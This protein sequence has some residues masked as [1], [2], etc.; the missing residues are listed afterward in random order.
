MG[1]WELQAAPLDTTGVHACVMPD[2]TV[3]YWSYDELE[4]NN[5]DRCKWQLWDEAGGP[6]EPTARI[7]SRNLF[8]AGHCWLG[9]GRL[10]VAG[11]QSWNW[12][13]QGI[14]GADHDIHTYSPIDRTWT[15]HKDMPAGRYYPTCLTL[16]DGT[17]LIVSGAWTRV[18]SNG[19]NHDYEIFDGRTNE[20]T[21]RKPFNPGFMKADELYPFMQLLPDG[22][23]TGLVWVHAGRDSRLFSPAT[24]TWLAPTFTTTGGGNRNYPQQGAA[25]MLPLRPEDNYRTRV[26]LVG[27]GESGSDDATNTAQIFEFNRG[28]P[29]ASRYREP[30]GG[31]Q[32]HR[33]FMGDAV[34]LADGSVLVCGGA[35]GGSADHS[36][37]AVMECEVFDAASESFRPEAP[38][39]QKRMYHATAVLLPSGRVAVA[40]HTEHWNPNEPVE[41]HTIEVFTPD[42]LSR[43]ARP[44]LTGLPGVVAYG[45]L[46]QLRTPDA[47]S[48]QQVALVRSG[49]VTHTNNMDQRWVGAVVEK[50]EADALW[51][52]IPRDR[53]VLP[54][55]PYMAFL[56]NGDGVPSVARFLRVDPLRTTPGRILA[57]DRWISVPESSALVKTEIELLPGD[58]FEIEANGEIWAGVWAT[59]KNGPE[60][61]HN[62][63]H[64]PKFPL[65]VGANAHP[66]S[67]IGRIEGQSWFYL[68]RR[69]GPASYDGGQPGRLEL[70]TN[71]D[72][73][74]NGN[75]TFNCHIQVWREEK[76]ARVRIAEV[77]ANPPGRDVAVND[78]E[79]VT[80]RNE[81]NQALDLAGWSLSD[82]FGHRARIARP[83][84]LGPQASLEVHTGPGQDT[85]TKLFIGRRQAIWNNDGDTVF[86]H[87]P[88]GEVVDTYSYG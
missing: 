65:N 16:T 35:S 12:V 59:G 74:G 39:L 53:A 50:R 54:P 40:G 58:D 70:R 63:D 23:A 86:L 68:G 84:S 24:G 32:R 60:G 36:H 20:L 26:L 46:A 73:P 62:V 71:D 48:I 15:R 19:L 76:A 7:L 1:T 85:S 31:R 5:V 11:G 9:D 57:V 2:E 80:L 42:Y 28:N 56:L 17:A 18:P 22:T 38:I 29:A 81:G 67:L 41:D 30:A 87:T 43:G 33:R 45:E 55:G 37:A 21:Q 77:I 78:G 79:Y 34:V 25:V 61:W 83:F 52:R 6:V 10:L 47:A 13:T 88:E 51:I 72:S 49:T 3:L 14:W 69:F 4:E 8:C 66:Y 27:G 75:G 44:R 64:D 82:E